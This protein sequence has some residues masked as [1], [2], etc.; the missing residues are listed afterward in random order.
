M[1]MFKNM[2]QVKGPAKAQTTKYKENEHDIQLRKELAEWS[3]KEAAERFDG[4]N[5]I[6]IL[7]PSTLD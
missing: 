4:F 1:E 2:S 3:N 7:G 6:T 5:G